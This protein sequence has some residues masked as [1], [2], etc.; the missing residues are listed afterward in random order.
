MS[1]FDE[2]AKG[3]R[4]SNPVPGRA[5]PKA[6][7]APKIAELY[8]VW[9]AEDL[10]DAAMPVLKLE[11]PTNGMRIERGWGLERVCSINGRLIFGERERSV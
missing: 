4:V 11:L 6:G 5:G 1:K 7:L 10:P 3:G 8:W 9:S 2:R